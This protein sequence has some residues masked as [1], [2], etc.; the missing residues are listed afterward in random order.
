MKTKA[1]VLL[2][3]GLVALLLVSRYF[4]LSRAGIPLGWMLYLGLPITAA[5]VLFA[6]RL[7]S[8]SSGWSATV[9][10]KREG[11]LP[12]RPLA[13]P[14]PDASVSQRLKDLESL[15]A[16]GALSDTEYSAQRLQIISNM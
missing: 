9:D 12:A 2:S 13:L 5:G 14:P 6:L 3:G 8:L 7:I 10:P 4:A 11:G 16:S 15:H 1:V